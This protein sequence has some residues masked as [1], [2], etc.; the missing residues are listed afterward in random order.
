MSAFIC[1]RCG[2]NS[3]PGMRFCGNCGARL[4][5]T[6]ML[7]VATPVA[8]SFSPEHLGTMMGAD[9]MERFQQ[10]GL[11][12]AGQRRNVTV[13]FADISGYT[14][15][16]SQLDA[17]ETYNIIQQYSHLLATNVY[18]YDGMVDKFIGDGL[19]ALFGAPIAHENNAE[20]AARA[21]LDMQT[22]VARLSQDLKDQLGV[23]LKVRVGLHSGA[24]IVGSVGSNLMMNYTAIGNTVNLA[25][26][27]EQAAAPG[28]TIVSESLYHATKALFSYAPLP[29]LTLKGVSQPV[30]A[31][32]VLGSKTHPGSVR[33]IE[34]LHAPLVGRDAELGQLYQAVNRLIND[35]KGQFVLITGDAG[36]GKSRLTAEL[37]N[38]VRQTPLLILEGHSLTYRRAVS[39][40]IFQD[41]LRDYLGLTTDSPEAEVREQLARRVADSF[42]ETSGNLLPYLEHLLAL[43]PSDKAAAERLRYLDAGKLRQQIFAATRDLLVAEAH[44]RPLLLILEDLHWADEASLDLIAFLLDSLRDTPLIIYAISRPL[45]IG[46]LAEIAERARKQFP[47]RFVELALQSLPPSQSEQLLAQL[48]D[49][50][51]IPGS[52]RDQIIQRASGIPFYL[53]EILRMLIDSGLI[54]RGDD[55][56]QL[57]PG[58]DL[59]AIGVPGTLQDLILT[60]FDRLES[61]QRRILQVAS[62]IGRQFSLPLL[63]AVLGSPDESATRVALAHLIEREFLLPDA[64]APDSKY[65]FKHI[66]TSETIYSTL[67]KRERSILHGQVG[68]AIEKL[69]ANRLDSQIELLA[70]HYSWSPRLD[71]ALHYLLLAGRKALRG[72][73]N[74]QARQHL[75]QALVLLAEV[76]HTPEQAFEIHAGLGDVLMF[77]GEYP[78]A[79]SHYEDAL[80]IISAEPL[81]RSLQK[82]V[83][84]QR[85]VGTTF[86]RQ[87]SYDEALM[88]FD[89]AKATLNESAEPASLERAQTLNEIGWIHF[90]RGKF[91]EARLHLQEALALVGKTPA[92][93]IVASINNR[94]GAV[95][96]ESG[97]LTR[98]ADY[99]RQSLALSEAMGDVAGVARA[100]NNLGMMSW[101][102]GEWKQALENYSHCLRL[103]EQIGDADGIAIAHNNRGL[104]FTD[105]GNVAAARAELELGLKVAQ[106][107]GNMFYVARAHMNLGRLWNAVGDWDKAAAHLT[108]SEVL[109]AEIET[110]DTLADVLL[111]ESEMCVG[112]GEL[113]RARGLISQVQVILKEANQAESDHQGWLARQVGIIALTENNFV[114]AEAALRESAAIFQR[115]D[116]QFENAK[117]NYQ[118]GLLAS[119]MANAVQAKCHGEE[120]R[121]VFEKLGAKLELE[122]C[123]KLLS[124]L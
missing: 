45:Q 40:W 70:R 82:R 107:I 80:A 111:L 112:R 53:E 66:L 96:F 35:K 13:L 67:L 58:V 93:D 3:P 71:R 7:P 5:A 72:H 24:V 118:F 115:L 113:E 39:Y 33:G 43:E 90:Q 55:H 123:N 57:K 121:Q 110:R 4:G 11:E 44:N 50:P 6:G 34:G 73:A 47:D 105:Q 8:A 117:T 103:L 65:E 60:R 84:L 16:S 99:V 91:D 83:V 79:R 109:F 87:G 10:A 32:R 31:Y 68:E 61:V 54:Q 30:T 46:A 2:F 41:I 29:P 116:A 20:L 104:L 85:K 101:R 77:A 56:W 124:E 19:I 100:Y 88:C 25:S 26:R 106:Q 102:L 28:T 17:E 94:L 38:F 37:K 27:L 36:M 22:D 108:E 9:L 69:Y 12:A 64:D 81:A 21:A 51:N 42:W 18:K 52:L 76:R 59:A 120:A 95:A 119:K 98:A 86:A 23:E 89:L 62:V 1:A 48:L 15:L 14:A 78:P 92:H 49:M 75:E 63:N 122:K 97:D 114:G 74:S